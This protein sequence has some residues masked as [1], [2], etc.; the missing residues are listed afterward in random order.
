MI[1]TILAW[2]FGLAV[3]AL[4]VGGL[5]Q[6]RRRKVPKTALFRSPAPD[7]DEQRRVNDQLVEM[8]TYQR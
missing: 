2:V 7:E 3:L 1:A 6:S 4:L 5:I 8:K